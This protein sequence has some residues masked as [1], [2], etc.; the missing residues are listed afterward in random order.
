MPNNSQP[1]RQNKKRRAGDA[2][3]GA[4]PT[5]T[6]TPVAPPANP[7]P[8]QQPAAP[9]PTIPNGGEGRPQ[10]SYKKRSPW[11]AEFKP[12]QDENGEHRAQCLFCPTILKADPGHNG[13][14][15]LKNH[16]LMCRRKRSE[17]DGQMHLQFVPS[18]DDEKTRRVANWRFNQDLVRQAVA[19]MIMLDELP[20]RFVEH[21]GFK[22]L[23]EIACPKTNLQE[24]F[25][26]KCAGRVCI[27]TDC[28]TSIQNINYMCITA[29]FIDVDWKLNK[30][31]LNFCEIKSH[32]GIDI[33]DSVAD[34]LEEWN[35]KNVFCITMDN[36]TA[37]DT[38]IINLRNKF[39]TWGGSI[40][41]GK[42]LHMRCVAHIL[43]LVVTDGLEEVDVSV[44]RVREAVRWVRGS[45]ARTS[46]F[47][48]CVVFHGMDPKSLLRLDVATRWNSTYLMLE[49]AGKFEKPFQSLEGKDP[50]YKYNNLVLG[51]PRAEDWISIRNL[52]KYLKFFYDLTLVASGSSYVT[53]HLFVREMGKVFF[54]IR[55][56]EASEDEATRNMAS[57]MS[58]KLG[59]YWSEKDGRNDRF[60][61]LVY[62]ALVLD[63]R[64]KMEYPKFALK[65]LYGD[66]RGAQLL[67]EVNTEL[68]DIFQ[69]Y[70]SFH[71]AQHMFDILGW[72]KTKDVKY[73]VLSDIA[74]D[75]LA[76]PI[77]T[78][79]SESAFSTGGRVLD[80]FR[81]S[82]SPKIVEAVI[83]CGDWMRSSKFSSIQ[84]EEDDLNVTMDAGKE[85]EDG[86]I[87]LLFTFSIF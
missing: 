7:T 9:V 64:H 44:R 77:S 6:P 33:A 62:I 73:P 25:L 13:T 29:H 19:A 14:T 65:K 81:S 67:E 43:N 68:Q 12:F 87:S 18:L 20:F 54:H 27:T 50:S 40:L 38:A 16:T 23:M 60:N 57:R 55:Q 66:V 37:N 26:T 75:V 52:T 31:I 22:R 48:E 84:D 45:P 15:S 83:C 53:S 80:S 79:P 82:L 17:R 72:W 3:L 71:D 49:A 4:T 42:F 86:K 56:M 10:K 39:Q 85:L 61:R 58:K 59:K 2:R 47:K 32:R 35:L 78:V 46:T 36:A 76:I 11:W 74:R 63:P 24:Y 5:P 21:V 69:V 70:Q 51:P 1:R 41:G 28:W 8:Q 30:K 34:C